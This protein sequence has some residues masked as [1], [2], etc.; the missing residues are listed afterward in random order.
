MATIIDISGTRIFSHGDLGS[1][2]VAAHRMLDRGCYQ[3]GFRQLGAWLS[4]HE[5][6]GPQPG[7]ESQWI[8]IQWHMLV[9][10]LA[11]GAWEQ[12]YRRFEAHI[13]P[14]ARCAKTAATDAPA[15][16]WRLALA[17]EH[18]VELP[19][20]DVVVG[21][22]ARMQGPCDRFVQ[23]HNLLALA[24]AGDVEAIDA[25]LD[26]QRVRCEAD[27]VLAQL[28]WALRLYAAGDFADAASAIASALPGL[29]SVGGSHAQNELFVALY[30]CAS[31]RGA[32]NDYEVN[33]YDTTA[34]YA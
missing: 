32:A 6:D 30:R 21:A 20:A 26:T 27:R 17:A 9:F 24:G 7:Q 2:H 4:A 25:W 16:L 28:G 29:P 31:S 12:A 34:A 15:A 11:V 23:L 10:E 1:A 8:H 19:W 13:R 33:R 5:A 3:Q 18:E 14:A 22:K